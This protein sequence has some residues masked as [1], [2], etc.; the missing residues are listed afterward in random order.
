MNR[1]SIILTVLAVGLFVIGGLVFAATYPPDVAFAA[2]SSHAVAYTAPNGLMP[3]YWSMPQSGPGVNLAL[4]MFN[5][6]PP[7]LWLLLIIVWAGLALHA[8]QLAYDRWWYER[9]TRD[10]LAAPLARGVAGPP[11][12][13]QIAAQHLDDHAPGELAPLAAALIAG[14]ALPWV[15]LHHPLAGLAL[16]VTMLF[17]ALSAVIRGQ[18]N[19]RRIRQSIAVGLFAGWATV[20]GYAA[21]AAFT[22]GQLGISP[23][24]ATMTALLLCAGTGVTVQWQIG[25]SAS[26]SVGMIWALIGIATV[27]ISTVPVIAIGAILGITAMTAVLVRAVT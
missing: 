19:G 1:A 7:A 15:M 20:A 22:A 9:N 13:R 21:L 11:T 25:G 5:P 6:G 12:P 27:T 14:A 26:Y 16:A 4:K 18:R 23:D 24:T 8:L 17:A 10:R 3:D 2:R